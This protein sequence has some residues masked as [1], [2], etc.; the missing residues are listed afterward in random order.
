MYLIADNFIEE[1]TKYERKIID[2][3]MYRC[4]NCGT[5]I[6]ELYR[7]YSPNVLKLLKCETCG[8]LADK[9]IEYDSVII[10]VDLILLKRQAYRH[11]LYNCEIKHCWKLA[12]IL[13]LIESF[14]NF[15][16][17]NNNNEYVQYWKTFQPNFN[18]NCNLYL[19]IFS[20][21]FALISFVFTVIFLTKFK[22]YFYP[23]N[24]NTCSVI[25]LMKAL[26]IGGSGILLGLLEITWGHIFL[27]PHY[28]LILGYIILC[29][30][31][32]YSVVTNNK[33]LESLIILGIGMVV[34]KCISNY[35]FTIFKVLELV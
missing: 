25:H 35:S 26:I 34:Y 33:K 22:W 7:K 14:R 28:L 12:I 23:N 17:C 10:L 27:T 32:A 2:L 24:P 1:K 8:F 6:E 19:I 30:L 4:V 16:L 5:E 13:C 18:R 15:F 21:V 31:T 9:Y 3:I 11:L 20:T 29:L